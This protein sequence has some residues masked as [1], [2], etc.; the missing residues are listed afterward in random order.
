MAMKSTDQDHFVCFL[1]G[2]DRLF[3]VHMGI[4]KDVHAWR[5]EPDMVFLGFL[6]EDISRIFWAKKGEQTAQRKTTT[7]AY[8]HIT[9]YIWERRGQLLSGQCPPGNLRYDHDEN[10]Q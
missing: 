4:M 2:G 7:T 3:L 6:N 5:L 8:Y 9:V 10:N 1:W